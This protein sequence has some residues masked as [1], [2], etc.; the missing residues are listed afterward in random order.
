MFLLYL[1]NIYVWYQI[2]IF[3][4]ITDCAGQTWSW[5]KTRYWIRPEAALASMLS[6]R[7]KLILHF[8]ALDLIHSSMCFNTKLS[9][10]GIDITLPQDMLQQH[11]CLKYSSNFRVRLVT[12][13]CVCGVPDKA[14]ARDWAIWPTST[15]RLFGSPIFCSSFTRLN[16]IFRTFVKLGAPCVQELQYACI[17]TCFG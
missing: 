16:E 10:G 8:S 9:R 6:S 17:Q 11:V 7:K 2:C 3:W 1:N 5:I 15:R 12:D 13:V 4:C 14:R